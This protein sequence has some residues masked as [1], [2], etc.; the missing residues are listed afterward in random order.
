MQDLAQTVALN[1]YSGK[2]SAEHESKQ[3]Q[4]A[5]GSMDL[6]SLPCNSHAEESD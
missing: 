1:A 5:R 4:D 2:S 3:M 6:S